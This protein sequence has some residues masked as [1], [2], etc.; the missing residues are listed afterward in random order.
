MKPIYLIVGVPGSGKSTIARQLAMQ[1]TYVAHDDY[2]KG[3]YVEAIIKAARA[4]VSPILAETPFSISEIRTP[5]EAAGFKVMPV[6]IIE[7]ED[8]LKSRYQ[9][10]EGRPIIPGHLT[11]QKTYE[12]RAK[13]LGAFFGTAD[14]VLDH[15]RRVSK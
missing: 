5:L 11:R 10:R 7:P 4:S 8:V 3:G 13:D 15:L 6:F 9:K 12:K 2:M 14:Q 1:F